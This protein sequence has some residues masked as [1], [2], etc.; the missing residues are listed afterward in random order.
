MHIYSGYTWKSIAITVAKAVCVTKPIMF[1]YKYM[2][3]LP[4]Q[5]SV[6]LKLDNDTDNSTFEVVSPLNTEGVP[7]FKIRKIYTHF[8]INNLFESSVW[9]ETDIYLFIFLFC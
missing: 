9:L 5:G 8:N 3:I 7:F 4:F 6:Q 1:M 2:H